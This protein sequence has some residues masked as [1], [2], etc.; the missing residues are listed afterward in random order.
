VFGWINILG[1]G[2]VLNKMLL[3]LRV[4]DSPIPLLFNE[5]GIIIGLVEWSIPY[6][7]LTLV[8]S[9]NSVDVSL[10]QAAQNLGATEWQTFLR[11]TLPLTSHGIMASGI[12]CFVLS[13]SAFIFPMLL[14]GGRVHLLAA[15]VYESMLFSFNYPFASATAVIIL[16]IVFSLTYFASKALKAKVW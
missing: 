9:I 14:G 1:D 2:G 7:T 10:E 15:Q 5:T 16:L 8:G 13:T 11:I 4:T 3:F 6:A 12:L